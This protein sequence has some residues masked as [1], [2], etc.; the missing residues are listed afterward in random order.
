M[1]S[2]RNLSSFYLDVKQQI[3]LVQRKASA[4]IGGF[5]ICRSTPMPF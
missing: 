2:E 5:L 4:S 3:N 1:S